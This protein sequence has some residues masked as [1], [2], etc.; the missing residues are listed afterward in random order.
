MKQYKEYIFNIL[1]CIGYG[2]LCGSVTGVLIFF[3]KLAAD[4]LTKLSA[5]IYDRA[6][7]S[8]LIIS[9]VFAGLIVFACLT[10][11][12][13]EKIPE[14]RGG[15]I[16]RCEGILRG[17]LTFSRLRTLAGTAIGSFISFFCG[18]PVGSEGPAVL[19]GTSL[20][21]ICSGPD[22]KKS[23]WSRYVMSGGAAAGFAVATGSPLSAMLFAL[24]EIHKR[25]TPML[26]LTVSVSVL[27][28]TFFNELLCSLT[29][30]SP[31]LITAP[32]FNDFKLEDVPH[33]LALGVIVA[34]A[35]GFFD[36]SLGYFGKF[37]KRLKI[38]IPDSVRLIAVFV[39]SGVMGLFFREGAFSGHD[40]IENILS[41]GE[42]A[43]LLIAVLAVRM[44]MM[45]LVTDS[46]A[47]GG[48]FVPTLAIGAL[49][50]AISGRML[51]FAGMPE[52]LFPAVVM[53]GMCAFLGGTLRAPLTAAIFFTEL[54]G[55]F[56]NFFYV[57]LVIFVVNCITNI[58]NQ[59][60]F[61]DRV[62]ESLEENQNE[63]K[64]PR[65]TSFRMK[66]SDG[67]FVTGKTVRD[68][69]WPPSCVV[70]SITRA[71]NPCQDLDHDG[72]KKLFDGDTVI[73]RAKIYDENTLRKSLEGLV[74]T[75]YPI[76][77]IT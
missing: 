44:L 74:G 52:D 66:V 1:P 73:V 62:L 64:Q 72:E 59:T 43:A 3:Y 55:R 65:I 42:S 32:V 53:L 51:V 25:F 14:M 27:S 22:W 60:P 76:E 17:V 68:I 69:M 38:K 63:G 77:E 50:G 45:I 47:T 48:I 40:I 8:P 4:K 12:L 10:A 54:T 46:G 34:L 35:V 15:G 61:Y 13:Q 39:F 41:Y 33:L 56:T 5:G 9:A 23:A 16:P 49:V 31:A 70:L 36:A 26:V 30:I 21:G 28:A 75:Q 2:L 58:F 7:H 71:D 20:G 24:E 11:F 57:A 6:L 18:L 67:A 19:I 37:I 29:G